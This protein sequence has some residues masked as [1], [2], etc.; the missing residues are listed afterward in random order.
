[1][2]EPALG[3]V[4]NHRTQGSRARAHDFDEWVHFGGRSGVHA[5]YLGDAERG[6][7]NLSVSSLNRIAQGLGVEPAALLRGAKKAR[8]AKEDRLYAAARRFVSLVR[9][10]SEPERQALLRILREASR[11]IGRKPG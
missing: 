2:N 1:M 11:G 3:K 4:N 10:K 5:N 7:R 8:V 6:R 9:D